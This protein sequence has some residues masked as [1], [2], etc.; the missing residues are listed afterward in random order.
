[1]GLCRLKRLTTRFAGPG[2]R[3][4]RTRPRS[5]LRCS[6]DGPDTWSLVTS[7]TAQPSPAD[8][9]GILQAVAAIRDGQGKVGGGPWHITAGAAAAA[10]DLARAA[11]IPHRVVSSSGQ[12]RCV[13]GED[14]TVDVQSHGPNAARV[15]VG[16]TCLKAPGSTFRRFSFDRNYEVV[17]VGDKWIARFEGFSITMPGRPLPSFAFARTAGSHSLAAAAQR[18]R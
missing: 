12:I 9:R 3:A 10:T 16:L 1:L 15:I 11:N 2:A 13:D 8:L 5:A 17:R 6:E 14:V 7:A 18:G 4:A